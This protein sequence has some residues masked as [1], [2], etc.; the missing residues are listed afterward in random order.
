MA[1]H[2]WE[3]TDSEWYDFHTEFI[4]VL[5]K[6]DV[7]GSS[8]PYSF[9]RALDEEREKAREHH[10]LVESGAYLEDGYWL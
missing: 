3:L 1:R 2:L 8:G 9:Y 5:D 6:F 10:V 4:K 7:A